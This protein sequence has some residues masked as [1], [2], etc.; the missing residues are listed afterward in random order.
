[1]KL[2]KVMGLALLSEASDPFFFGK[3]FYR[4]DNTRSKKLTFKELGALLLV[5]GF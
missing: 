1:M 4:K 2:R 5:A 3:H